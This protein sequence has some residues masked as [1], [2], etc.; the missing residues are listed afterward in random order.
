[1]S[2]PVRDF[3]SGKNVL[4]TGGTGYL[5]KMIIEKL[6]RTTQVKNIYLIVRPKQHVGFDKRV[7]K[8]FEEQVRTYILQYVQLTVFT[9]IFQVFCHIS[10][11]LFAE[12]LH[13]IEGDLKKKF[14][15]ISNENIQFL[16]ENVSVGDVWLY[17]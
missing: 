13:P 7:S 2:S 14:L 15:G 8:M 17:K 3:Y 4:L 16:R 11:S 9:E 10:E 1:M 5:G 6:L 12:K